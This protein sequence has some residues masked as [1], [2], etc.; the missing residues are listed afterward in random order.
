MRIVPTG[1]VDQ[2]AVFRAGLAHICAG[3]QF[4]INFE[5]SRLIDVPARYFA[6]GLCRIIL[7]SLC[8]DRLDSLA[9]IHVL[10]TQHRS[11]RV[12]VLGDR[13]SPNELHAAF[14]A[15]VD[16]LLLKNEV[17][18]EILLKS[19]EL[20]LLGEAVIS[21]K[22]LRQLESP[23]RPCD[24]P[25]PEERLSRPECQLNPPP[26]LGLGAEDRGVQLSGRE[27]TILWQ[28]AQGASNK[29]IARDLRIAEGTIKVHVRSL[30]RKI[31]ANN[32][33][34][35]A[36]WAVN[37]LIPESQVQGQIKASMV[38]QIAC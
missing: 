5:Y 8:E 36:I 7:V 21:P 13:F 27:Q 26:I 17:N 28:L 19:L 1:I 14:D 25:C 3:S 34:Q 15:N 9:R 18:A 22:L 2:A 24:E 33:T 37:H 20:I 29:H 31:H 35:A 38:H 6:K 4:R 32:R 16:G 11:L 23:L 30:L 12:C 10:K